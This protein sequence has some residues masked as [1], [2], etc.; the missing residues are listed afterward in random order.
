MTNGYFGV[1]YQWRHLIE[2]VV[3]WAVRKYLPGWHLHKD[4]VRKEKIIFAEGEE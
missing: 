2:R 4:P 1:R 3:R